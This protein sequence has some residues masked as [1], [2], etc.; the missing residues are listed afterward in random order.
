MVTARLPGPRGFVLDWCGGLTLAGC[1]VPTRAALSLTSSRPA[2]LV[3]QF[4][5][6]LQY[7]I[8]EPLPLW[9]MGFGLG[10]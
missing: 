6:C 2:A 5:P 3:V 1:R 9:L 8:P 7:V 4:F 10:Q